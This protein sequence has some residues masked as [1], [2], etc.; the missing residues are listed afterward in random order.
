MKGEITM[1]YTVK[2]YSNLMGMEGFSE[3]LLKIT[4]PSTRA[5]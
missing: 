4:L 2:D 5:T 1:A 3:T